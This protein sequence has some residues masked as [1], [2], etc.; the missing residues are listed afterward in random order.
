MQH[1]LLV[2]VEKCCQV[3]DK[4]GCAWSILTKFSEAFGCI[5]HELLVAKLHAHGFSLESLTFIQS[6]LF[7]QIQRLKSNS[8]FS[9]YSKAE[10]GVPQ[11]SISGSFIFIISI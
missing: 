6:Y 5:N 8:S 3:L 10:S 1:C 2:L 7:N 4:Q 9:D 11:G